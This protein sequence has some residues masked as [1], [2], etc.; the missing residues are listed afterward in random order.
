M[1]SRLRQTVRGLPRP[2]A[3]SGS[4]QAQHAVRRPG[5]PQVGQQGT[6]RSAGW[7]AWRASTTAG[8][9]GAITAGT[10][11]SGYATCLQVFRR[12]MAERFGW[13]TPKVFASATV[14]S[15]AA[16]RARISAT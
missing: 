15:P 7:S 4:P 3:G 14:V 1:H 10:G 5:L 8:R 13:L 16:W 2:V 12:T 6:R 9:S 11:G